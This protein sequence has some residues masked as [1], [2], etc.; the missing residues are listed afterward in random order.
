MARRM[1]AGSGWINTHNFYDPALPFG[2]Y[3]QSGWDR[4]EGYEAIR[5]FTEVKSVCVALT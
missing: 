3:K 2:G 4:G 5:N 1:K